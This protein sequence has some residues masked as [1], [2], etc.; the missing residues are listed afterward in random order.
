MAL[1]GKA[2]MLLSFDIEPAEAIVEHDDWHTHEH[3]PER[4][5]IPGFLRGSRW[6][7]LKGG[8]RYFVMYEVETLDVLASGPY[9]ERL[10]SPSPWTTK[11]MA[12]YRGM[13]RGL[14]RVIGSF[15]AGL[16]QA[17]LLIRFRPAPGKE[18]ALQDWLLTDAL[19]K[20]PTLPGLT[21]A[22]LFEGAMA[23]AITNEQ[24]IRGKDAAVDCAVV[25]TGYDIE[26]LE[27]LGKTE[28]HSKEFEQRGATGIT[29][30]VYRMA[31]TLAKADI[32]PGVG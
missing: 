24:R 6:I 32:S 22:H 13:I 9:L 19:P 5:S 28:L 18:K 10:N 16:G 30:G 25:I 29:S 26:S 31:H 2:A 17:V 14:C 4:L 11:M 12:H 3:F 21:G 27:S 1:I 8:P 23:A 7:A 15:G 20:L